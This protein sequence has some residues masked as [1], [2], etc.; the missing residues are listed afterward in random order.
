VICGV[1]VATLASHVI[2]GLRREVQ[3]AQ[4]LGQYTLEEKLGE[5]GMGI[6]YRA[7]HA[8]LRRPTAIK[9]LPPE[10]AGQVALERFER[11]VQLTAALSHPNTVSVF[12]YGRTPDGV[13]YYAMEYLDG[14]NL[15]DLVQ[16]YGAQP[17]GRVVSILGQVCGA[18]AEAHEAAV[19]GA[20]R[21]A[22]GVLRPAS[23]DGQA[24]PW[25]RI[26]RLWHRGSSHGP[27]TCVERLL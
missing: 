19:R 2:Y 17:P 21:S 9:L 4:R 24:G 5:G 14:I 3:N 10:K 15:E 6:V 27:A 12:D 7:R 1:V 16:L 8:M 11:E 13:F 22:P 20:Q 26:A 23:C 18:L 25:T